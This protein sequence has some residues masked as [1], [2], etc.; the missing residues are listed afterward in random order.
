MCVCVVC[1]CVVCVCVCVCVWGGNRGNIEG[2]ISSKIVFDV[3]V[4]MFCFISVSR[5]SL[6]ISKNLL[7]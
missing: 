3:C 6:Y 1:V 2:T 7:V 4:C 5:L